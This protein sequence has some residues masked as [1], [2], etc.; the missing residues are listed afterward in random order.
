MC[1]NAYIY[2]EMERS[3][4]RGEVFVNDC[5]IDKTIIYLTAIYIDMLDLKR[6]Y[7]AGEEG[8]SFHPSL[9]VMPSY[10]IPQVFNKIAYNFKGLL[11]LYIYYGVARKSYDPF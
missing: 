7:E 4:V 9:I 8:M 5:G 6:R 1:A 10:L 3:S 11:V 2:R